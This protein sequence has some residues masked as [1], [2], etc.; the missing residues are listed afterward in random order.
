MATSSER[1][2][3]TYSSV[4]ILM[5]CYSFFPFGRGKWLDWIRKVGKLA[6]NSFASCAQLFNLAVKPL[7]LKLLLDLHSA[8]RIN[9]SVIV[10]SGTIWLVFRSSF[11][12]LGFSCHQQNYERDT[13]ASKSFEKFGF[14]G[15]VGKFNDWIVSICNAFT[16]FWFRCNIYGYSI[17]RA[18]DNGNNT[19]NQ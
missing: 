15:F 3:Q 13:C 16:T 12:F 19:Q 8:Q 11:R 2:K 4:Q 14:R 5:Q 17:L 18:F 7:W 6:S 1:T 10:L 9:Q